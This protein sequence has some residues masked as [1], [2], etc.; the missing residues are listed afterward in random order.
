[1]NKNVTD[2]Y[3]HSI[4]SLLPYHGAEEKRYI[5]DLRNSVEDYIEDEPEANNDTLIAEFGEPTEVVRDYVETLDIDLLIRKI[6]TRELFRKLVSIV[7]IATVLALSI[8]ATYLHRSYLDFKNSIITEEE[9][10]I[11]EEGSQSE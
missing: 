7:L 3:I 4:Y 8:Y 2:K 11:I 5:E 10:T 9:T 6:S 1:M